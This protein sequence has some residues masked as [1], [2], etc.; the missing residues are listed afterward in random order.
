PD[1]RAYSQMGGD[2]GYDDM[3][4]GDSGYQQPRAPRGPGIDVGKF[5]GSVLATALVAGIAGW[6][7]AW[8]VDAVC[9]RFG[10][11]W[12]NGGV[13]PS[14]DAVYGAVA[15]ILAGVLWYLL[16]VGTAKAQQCCSWVA[17]LLSVAAV[18]P[19][20]FETGQFLYGFPP[21]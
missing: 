12:A 3:Y 11:Q 6:L 7:G 5:A 9:S 4:A 14:R 15:A 19:T 17:G 16:L 1:S 21:T 18:T 8:I 20:L 13:T 2:P 10:H